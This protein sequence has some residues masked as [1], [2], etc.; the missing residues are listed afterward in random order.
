[1]YSIHVACSADLSWY[2]TKKIYKAMDVNGEELFKMVEDPGQNC[3]AFCC[4]SITTFRAV[5]KYERELFRV[6]HTFNECKKKVQKTKLNS[7]LKSSIMDF[8]LFWF[9]RC[10][11]KLDITKKL[12]YKILAKKMKLKR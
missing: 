9:N 12:S 4:K 2:F 7:C 1:M 3:Y 10:A 11:F 6:T 8:F 5:N